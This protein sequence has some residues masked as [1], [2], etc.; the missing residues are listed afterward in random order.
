[1][2]DPF[3]RGPRAA[4]PAFLPPVW[5]PLDPETGLLNLSD[6]S[7]PPD[8]FFTDPDVARRFEAATAIV[9][10]LSPAD[11]MRDSN[12][13]LSELTRAQWDLDVRR[14]AY[15]EARERSGTYP[16]DGSQPVFAGLSRQD[17]AELGRYTAG[18]LLP[19]N[20]PREQDGLFAAA[21]DPVGDRPIGLVAK[22]P[23]LALAGEVRAPGTAVSQAATADPAPEPD[24]ED[25][26][27]R[28]MTSERTREFVL[29][30][31]P[32]VGQIRAGV[33]AV[34]SYGEAIEAARR[35][36]WDAFLE[37]GGM[38]LLNTAGVISGP[39]L[40]PFFRLARLGMRRLADK[41]PGVKRVVA[42]RGLKNA[43]DRFHKHY[44]PIQ[45]D[46][47]L[48]R[49]FGRLTD[50]QKKKIAGIFPNAFG[51]AAERQAIR[52]MENAGGRLT[53]Q[54]RGTTTTV[55]V[56]GRPV[57]RRYDAKIER[58]VFVDGVKVLDPDARTVAVEVKA[59]ASRS[60]RQQK[61][62][63][64]VEADGKFAQRVQNLRY[65]VKT[66]PEKELVAAFRE[67]LE[68]HVSDGP[69]GLTAKHV[70][71]IV[72]RVKRL[73]RGYGDLVTAD[74]LAG[75]VAREAA[76]FV[77]WDLEDRRRMEA[78]NP[79]AAKPRIAT[80]TVRGPARRRRDAGL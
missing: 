64:A 59:Q 77:A 41:T 13:K 6:D 54:G 34:E 2:T 57:T 42:R 47:A 38:G 48:G 4:R 23:V 71:Q 75:T 22:E 5:P 73:R 61:I 26:L 65:P 74:V 50:D 62:D 27:S 35:E 37:H 28:V 63:R 60:A 7:E 15:E 32:V 69:G 30:L 66:I 17:A 43:A 70:D 72:G 8:G 36:D 76:N 79:V 16:V 14:R 24:D 9:Q 67:M 52:Q 51:L 21:R 40:G 44:D 39:V 80:G 68:K 3:A 53:R 11:A 31:V 78:G 49:T 1:M 55:N 10:G 19:P 45:V 29:D 18:G 25:W 58:D 46:K 33:D 20:F 56:G 12:R